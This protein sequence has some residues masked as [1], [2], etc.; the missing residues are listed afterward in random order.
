VGGFRISA[1]E[2]SNDPQGWHM[3]SWFVS[4][5][6]LVGLPGQVE[7]SDPGPATAQAIDDAVVEL[8]ASQFAVRRRA[9]QFLW[10]QGLAAEPALVRAAASDDREVR[11]RAELI[12]HD[13]RYGILPGVPPDIVALIRQFRDG[14][15]NERLAALERLADRDCFDAIQRLIQLEPDEGIRRQLLVYL[16]QN[17][18]AVERFFEPERLEQLVAA[19]GADRDETW[20]R[21]VLAQLLFSPMIIRQLADKRRL[22]VLARIVDAEQ[23]PEVRR[24][25][26]SM[27]FQNA[28]A[29]S[30]LIEND[31]LP[32]VLRVIT[33]E[34]DEKTRGAWIS[35][36]LAMSGVIQQ[37][38]DDERL[39]QLL[40][41]AQQHVGDQQ[42]S[43]ILEQLFRSS[44]VLKTVLE[45]RGVDRLV[46]LT[47]IE[48]DA[49]ARGRILAALVTSMAVREHLTESGQYALAIRLARQETD[50]TARGEYLKDV[51]NSVIGY[52]LV[53]DQDS[54]TALWSLLKE[55]RGKPEPQAADWRSVALLRMLTMSA[56]H[57][58]LQQADQAAWLMQ[59]LRDAMTPA[60][61]AAIVERLVADYRLKRALLQ[62][63]HFD[64]LLELARQLPASGR[65]RALGQLFASADPFQNEHDQVPVQLILTLARQET[66]DEPRRQYLQALFRNQSVMNALITGGAYDDLWSLIGDEQN[67]LEHAIL[68]GEFL[69]TSGVVQ[70]IAD[71]Q[72]IDALLHFAQQTSELEVRREYL[73]RLFDSTYAMSA[74]IDRGHFDALAALADG[75]QDQDARTG[76]LSQFYRNSRVIQQLIE[77]DRVGILLEFAL[78]HADQK[79]TSTFLQ[80]LFFNQQAVAALVQQ[81]RVETMLDLARRSKDKYMRA[82]LLRAIFGLPEVVNHYAGSD[83]LS[84]MFAQIDEEEPEVRYQIYYNM[85]LRSDTLAVLI[86]RQWIGNLLQSLTTQV[87][88]K[89]RG[90]LLGRVVVQSKVVDYLAEHN[91][92]ERVIQLAGQLED[93]T[94]RQQYL[95]AVFS[96]ST[97]VGTLIEQ[98]HFEE[99]YRLASSDGNPGLRAR[100]RA[101]LLTNSRAVE[102]LVSEDNIDL[103]LTLVQEQTDQATQASVLTRIVASPAAIAALIKQ[104][105][106]SRLFAT[107][108]SVT[109]PVARRRMVAELLQS[110]PAIHQLAAS[111]DLEAIVQDV[112]RETEPAAVHQF[113]LRLFTR[114]DAVAA[115]M[116]H[117]HFDHLLQ[118]AE[119]ITDRAQRQS[120]LGNLVMNST[121]TGYLAAHGRI[122]LVL[123]VI[124][125]ES[126][127]F[128][129]RHYLNLLLQQSEVTQAAVSEG[130][131]DHILKLIGQLPNDPTRHNLL[132]SLLFQ[133]ATLDL[134]TESSELGRVQEILEQFADP[135]FNRVVLHRLLHSS[136]GHRLLAEAAL[137]DSLLALIRA[138]SETA[139][140]ES[141]A[142]RVLAGHQV[143]QA[144]IDAGQAHVI[145]ELANLV[146]DEQFRRSA[147]SEVLYAPSGLIVYHLRRGE[148]ELAEQLLQRHADSDLGRLRLA[149][150]LLVNGRAGARID[151]LQR[152]L[153]SSGSDARAP[154]GADPSIAGSAEDTSLTDRRLL[155]YLLRATGDLQAAREVAEQV[156]DPALIRAVSI[157]A[158][159]WARAAALIR[160]GPQL[161][162]IPANFQAP[163]NANHQRAE[164]LGLLAACQRLAGDAEGCEQSLAELRQLA[165]ANP[166][167]QSLQWY[168]VEALL[169]NGHA[170]DGL[171][172]LARTDPRRAFDLY[173]A[174][175]EYERALAVA[176]WRPAA[177]PDPQW[178]QSL[179]GGDGPADQQVLARVEFALQVA[180][181]LHTVGLS[182]QAQRV[183]DLLAD[184]VGQSEG[185]DERS[186]RQQGWERLVAGRV[187]IGDVQGAWQTAEDAGLDTAGQ[188]NLL[189][190]LYARRHTEARG[191]WLFYRHREAS[192]T[193]AETLARVHRMLHPASDSDPT[194][195]QA[196][197]E[198][199]LKLAETIAAGDRQSILLGVGQTCL[200]Q[201]C[202]RL[203]V[204]CA[205]QLPDEDDSE[206]LLLRARALRGAGQWGEAAEAF[207][208]VWR[209]DHANL[210]ALYLSGDALHQADG[211]EAGRQRQQQALQMALD[212]RARMRLAQDLQRY[213]FHEL[214]VEQLQLV[215]RT[216]PP[217]HAEWHEA[218]RLLSEQWEESGP[219]QAVRLLEQSLLD[220]LRTWFY[221]LNYRDYLRSPARA[222]RLRA[223]AAIA[224]QQ[225]DVADAQVQRALEIL[226]GDIDLAQ[227]L[228]PQ[229]EQAQ[230]QGQAD[231]LFERVCRSYTEP[232]QQYPNSGLLHNDYAWLLARCGR[233]LD[234]ALT[235]ARRAVQL[236]PE[237]ASYL[238]TLAEV[239]FRRGDR[240]AALAYS[241]RAV[242][243]HPESETLREQQRRFQEETPP[244]P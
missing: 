216:A 125:E 101:G 174:R 87:E 200:R 166:A 187:E 13:F 197:V 40:Q 29:V 106:F 121:A 190:R 70:A 155:V 59:Y 156:G 48:K 47:E 74:L 188:L 83:Q 201:E 61:R 158:G 20:R 6:L 208:E 9:S 60:D 82:S 65:G 110:G 209:V 34:P 215:L 15:S 93:P 56:G 16:M 1:F 235:H 52:S 80:H 168:C 128:R 2:L 196:P 117:G 66:E 89:Q 22:D 90:Q 225:W 92:L 97:L 167:D 124:G 35:Q 114:S 214:A 182:E 220:D 152:A 54:R 109:D 181:A 206:A 43:Q 53:R 55:E 71:K 138:E 179:P 84:E 76:L 224:A 85:T 115:V 17:P 72:Q 42:R 171:D 129:Q 91:Q 193:V 150:Y 160:S 176:G 211:Q 126:E 238:D 23:S 18:R 105:K 27:L 173:L 44:A 69:R 118:A 146:P 78:A 144:L 162:P 88:P 178:L 62:H 212:S 67:P 180:R 195:L 36:L 183:L 11:I 26:L 10:Q 21:T 244:E 236:V 147:W 41:F 169:L 228:L 51:L 242:R 185:E 7:G 63:G 191:W 239:H 102:H 223:A 123:R 25:M 3:G 57:E 99:L 86:E 58:L 210:A 141:Y 38:A 5:A 198:Q 103:L 32:F 131:F 153:A 192:D 98:G 19:V 222:C 241:R 135:N 45:K 227:Q 64:S 33:K 68:R 184:R 186:L 119:A 95:D 12:L 207:H 219:S 139:Y 151:Q 202:Y 108:S 104:D 100:L 79:Q 230:R 81:G 159:D 94:S 164:Q 148:T 134:L 240:E 49:A 96:S 226:P 175:H 28:A 229:L 137:G 232:L 205:Q 50:A 161:L 4:A 14:A 170:D 177:D 142:R 204:R 113:L 154:D 143:W 127:P 136:I 199:A 203:A 233:H 234:Q 112:L 73:K 237:N 218:A 111:G 77:T 165:T 194:A 122:D 140:Q 8:G 120:V 130:H 231:A 149:T 172:L 132:A 145:H 116:A 217:E 107:C 75:D 189:V 37:L 46:A 163:E 221:L 213:G 30:S 39:E 24:Q 133:P 157:E 31:Q 243:L